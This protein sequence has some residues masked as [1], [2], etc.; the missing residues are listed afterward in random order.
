M[1]KIRR[2]Q[3]ENAGFMYDISNLIAIEAWKN[4]SLFPDLS[5]DKTL[6]VFSDYSRVL[7]KYKTY[8]F[9]VIGRSGADYFNGSRKILRNDFNLKNR[10]MSYKGLNDKIKLK[11]LEPFLEIAQGCFCNFWSVSSER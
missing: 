10:R 1:V 5:K 2:L 3:N 7:G 9:L 6:F 11:A 8:T 4:P